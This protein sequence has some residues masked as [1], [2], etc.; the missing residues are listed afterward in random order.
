MKRNRRPLVLHLLVRSLVLL[1]MS[2]VAVQAQAPI[3]VNFIYNDTSATSVA[4]VGEF[5]GPEGLPMMHVG[6]GTWTRVVSLP[7]GYYGY[8]FL[9][10][11]SDY[12]LNPNTLLR[13][14]VD[15]VECSA[16]S[17]G[18]VPPTSAPIS[19][20]KPAAAPV[21][22]AV[23]AAPV[24]AGAAGPVKFG[25][26]DLT[27]GTMSSVDVPLS[28]AAWD[29][30]VRLRK[31]DSDP[32]LRV[33]QKPATVHMGISIP[34]RFDPK[35]S[36]PLLIV[37]GTAGQSSVDHLGLY[38]KAAGQAGWVAIA[39]DSARLPKESD[40]SNALRWA[41]VSSALE[42]LQAQW[43]AA[44]NWPVACGGFSGGAKRSGFFGALMCRKG[45][46]LIGMWMGG[47]NEDMASWGMNLYGPSTAVF[48]R[49]PIFL[50]SGKDDKTAT[51]KQVQD[52]MKSMKIKGFHKVQLDSYAG[53]HDPSDAQIKAG[54]DWFVEQSNQ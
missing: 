4:L 11:G 46:H 9:V 12:V 20:P 48:T 17:V 7:P 45:Y 52:V 28:A 54:L 6:A 34:P 27:P 24:A 21:A 2:C 3:T 38:V 49:T 10:N 26:V 23:A 13:K 19:A 16:I 29:D 51:P 35:R 47:C 1:L 32:V 36:W 15:G 44:K 43:P 37:N 53:K 40:D 50:S 41:L 39:A 30:A 14:T 18:G 25:T 8:R 42:Y 33:A 31:P 5:T 22:G